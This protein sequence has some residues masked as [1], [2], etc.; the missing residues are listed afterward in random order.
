[1]LA[2]LSEEMLAELA[3]GSHGDLG[4]R[5]VKLMGEFSVMVARSTSN[6]SPSPNPTPRP[7]PSPSPN[8]V[9]R[10]PNPAPNPNPG[11]NPNQVAR[12]TSL[13]NPSAA[14]Y[15]GT[16]TLQD[17]GPKESNTPSSSSRANTPGGTSRGQAAGSKGAGKG[18][19]DKNKMEVF[20]LSRMQAQA[21]DAVALEG[22]MQKK[23]EKL[24]KAQLQMANAKIIMAR[25][26]KLVDL[27]DAEIAKLTERADRL[28]GA[29]ER[30]ERL[31]K[32]HYIYIY[33][34]IYVYI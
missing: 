2:E 3:D 12:S 24:Q 22:E 29:Q 17:L 18:V 13:G 1:M 4:F 7:S 23:T 20:Y 27:K 14:A 11:P 25:H 34:Y 32:V 9:A 33:V 10:S 21:K 5:F 8:P 30:L 28:A 26:N 15:Q 16:L 6:L 19:V 31:A